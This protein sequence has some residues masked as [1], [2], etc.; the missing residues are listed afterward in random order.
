MF[1]RMFAKSMR[2]QWHSP[3]PGLAWIRFVWIMTKSA[4]SSQMSEVVR[5]WLGTY[6][7]RHALTEQITVPQAITLAE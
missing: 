3:D 1:D 6:A 2:T 7:R 4:R 5:A